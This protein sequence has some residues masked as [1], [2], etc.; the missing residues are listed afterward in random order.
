MSLKTGLYSFT[1][2]STSLKYYRYYSDWLSNC[3]G[4]VFVYFVYFY[5]FLGLKAI[6]ISSSEDEDYLLDYD[7]L[8][9]FYY[10]YYIEHTLPVILKIIIINQPNHKQ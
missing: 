3:S 2:F 6:T 9:P 1:S 5:Y 7:C 10:I 4:Y 8:C